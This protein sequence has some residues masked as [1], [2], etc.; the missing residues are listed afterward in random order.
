M[1]IPFDQRTVSGLPWTRMQGTVN[2]SQN[3]AKPLAKPLAF[4][5]ACSKPRAAWAVCAVLALAFCVFPSSA[6]AMG[7]K[8]ESR[9]EIDQLE[10]EWRDAV[11]SSNT[12][13][14]DS[15]LAVDYMGITASG[16]LQS[17]DETLQSLSSGKTHYTLLNIS[18]Q[19]VRFYATTAVVTSLANIQAT[20]PEGKVIGNYRYTHV[21]VRDAQ[22]DWKIVS[23]EASRVREPGPHK[24]SELH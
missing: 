7:Q 10:D 11:L 17:R 8:H 9:H 16:T 4:P 22:G 19:K 14:M 15:L 13:V 18:D 2:V 5:P 12:K 24:R 20:T 6:T 3:L 1:R 23:F 21:Y